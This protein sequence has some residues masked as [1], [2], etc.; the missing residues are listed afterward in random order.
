MLGSRLIHV[1]KRNLG[2][3]WS[4]LGNI[5]QCIV[6]MESLI[7]Y[8]KSYWCLCPRAQLTASHYLF[9]YRLG[10]EQAKGHFMNECC[11]R[12]TVPYGLTRFTKFLTFR[13]I[14][15]HF[16]TENVVKILFTAAKV[17]DSFQIHILHTERKFPDPRIL[18]FTLLQWSCHWTECVAWKLDHRYYPIH[19]VYRKYTDTHLASSIFPSLVSLLPFLF[20]HMLCHRIKLL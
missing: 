12:C 13:N 9:G 18:F 6:W 20:W 2:M 8:F 7:L 16:T 17:A 1:S 4:F 11:T 5:F 19:S 10:V 3:K 15:Q 14:G